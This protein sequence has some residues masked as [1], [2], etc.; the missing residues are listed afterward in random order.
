M[1]D[2]KIDTVKIEMVEME[3]M[4]E[5][6]HD[7]MAAWLGSPQRAKGKYIYI[8]YIINHATA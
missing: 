1:R 4:E 7:L 3:A 6:L 5:I 8:K 2:N